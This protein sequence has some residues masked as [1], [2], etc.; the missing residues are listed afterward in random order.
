MRR[1]AAAAIVLLAPWSAFS[2]DEAAV[3]RGGYI[4]NAAGCA[5]CHTDTKHDGPPLAGGR[6]LDTPF[7]VFYGKNITPDKKTGIGNWTEDEFRRAL[8]EGK[9]DDGQFLYP[10]FPFPSYTG[11]SDA[12]IADLYAYLMAQKPVAQRNKRHEVK[13]PFGYRRLLFFWRTLFFT[14][15]PLAP[16]AGQSE[17]WNRGRYLAEAVAHC[18]E[19]HTPRNFMGALDRARGF[20]G[21]PQGP[22]GQKA[23]NITSDV[24]T[25]IGKWSVDDIETVLDSGE[26]PDHDSVS[27]GMGLVVDG[28]A[29]LTAADRRAIAVYVKSLPPLRATGK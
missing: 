22:D 28:T 10:V 15:G 11:M 23:P 18:E 1:F 14:E 4:L 16:V 7:G 5:T 21:N 25:G 19:C 24:A 13:F 20:A 27:G 2:A 3:T 29:K 6:A 9:D 26:T 17:E 12:D 8:R